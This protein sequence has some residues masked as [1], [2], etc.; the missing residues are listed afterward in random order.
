MRENDSTLQIRISPCLCKT[1]SCTDY[2]LG[3]L[4]KLSNIRFKEN[5]FSWGVVRPAYR[6]RQGERKLICALLHLQ[7]R[8]GQKRQPISVHRPLPHSITCSWPQTIGR[9][10]VT[11]PLAQ[12]KERTELHIVPTTA[13]NYDI[14]FPQTGENACDALNRWNPVAMQ[15]ENG[16]WHQLLPDYITAMVAE[17]QNHKSIHAHFHLYLTMTSAPFTVLSCKLTD[18]LNIQYWHTARRN[19]ILPTSRTTIHISSRSYPFAQSQYFSHCGPRTAAS[20]AK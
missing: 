1:R 15:S 17:R 6:D 9:R 20:P 10:S 13:T 5:P 2:R 16:I 7:F 19:S 8:S 11:S 4:M 14:S 3:N 12:R 18:W